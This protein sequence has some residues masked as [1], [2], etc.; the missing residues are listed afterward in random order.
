MISTETDLEELALIH[1]AAYASAQPFPHIVFDNFFPEQVLE[2]ILNEFPSLEK[3]DSAISFNNDNEKKYAS[4]GEYHFGE[5]TKQFMYYLNSE[6]FLNFLEVLT[7]IQDLIPDSHFEGGGYHQIKRG[8]LLRIHTDFNKHTKTHLDR[9]LNV[10]IYLNKNWNESYGGHLQLWD[11]EMKS[12]VE[13][14]L[15]IFNRVVIFSTTD[16]SYHGHP[17]PLTCPEE[18]SRKSLALYYYTN[19]RP[20]HEINKGLKSHSTLFQLRVG[21]DQSWG[22]AILK[23]FVPPIVW[24]IEKKLKR[25]FNQVVNDSRKQI[26]SRRPQKSPPL[27][28]E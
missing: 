20:Q 14:I 3:A 8:G 24:K 19:G 12:A 10:L 4:K 1:K 6:P 18:M 28:P 7:G 2:D 25:K 26:R 22:E 23:D 16:F 11:V 21:V 27:P 9:R 15:P 17:D 13:K 5:R